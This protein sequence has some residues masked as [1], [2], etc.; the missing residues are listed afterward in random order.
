MYFS[1]RLI[2]EYSKGQSI[3]LYVDPLKTLAAWL[4]AKVALCV[5]NLPLLNYW[6]TPSLYHVVRSHPLR[7]HPLLH[8]PLGRRRETQLAN[9]AGAD[10]PGAKLFFCQLNHVERTG[11]YA[12]YSVRDSAPGAS[13]SEAGGR[14]G[15]GAAD[16]GAGFEGSGGEVGGEGGDVYGDVWGCVDV[17]KEAMVDWRCCYLI[18][19]HCYS[20][21]GPSGFKVLII[22]I[23]V[24]L[25]HLRLEFPFPFFNP[26]LHFERAGLECSH[27]RGPHASQIFPLLT[28]SHP[29]VFGLRIA[30]ATLEPCIATTL[31]SPLFLE[32]RLSSDPAVP[33]PYW[34]VHPFIVTQLDG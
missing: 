20:L 10:C 29:E 8:R 27:R 25:F 6:S 4:N 12:G 30:T 13:E 31:P 7:P 16:W 14:I 28:I 11:W 21:E 33:S 32:P 22:L 3:P 34:R 15:V 23:L 17:L 9:H 2:L 24:V 5:A 1:S 19:I 18:L 26:H